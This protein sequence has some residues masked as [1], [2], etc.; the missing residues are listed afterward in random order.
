MHN[1]DRAVLRIGTGIGLATGIC[2]GL[3][4]PMPH[5]GVIMAWVVLCRPG[6]PLGLKKGLAG[7]ILLLGIMASGVLLVPLLTH[8]A[9]AA[10]L[11]VGLLLYLLM[12]QAMAGKGAA[13]ML[14]IMAITVIPV[15]GLIEQSLAIAIAQMMGVGIL[16]GTLVNRMAH[17]LFPPQPVAGAA[18]RAAP[19]PP[20]HPERLALRAV[21]IVMP[22]WLLALGNPAFYIPAVMKTV[23]L[24]QQSTSLNAKQAGQELVLSTLAGALLAF[25]LWMGLSLWPSLLMLVLMLTLMT[26]WLAR[27]LVRL[28][29][30]RF[31]P[32]FWSNAWITA[33]I[34]FGP[35]IEDSATGKDVWLAAAMRCGL[36]LLVAGY[37][38]L[39]ILLLEQWRPVGRPLAEAKL[40]D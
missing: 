6:E 35:A 34:L 5:L 4:L 26:L 27:R 36:Y 11:L 38:W 9:L 28:V 31:P 8:Y 3:A 16:I 13:A 14:L 37:G 10:V 30:G 15:A 40:G 29:A 2:Y 39:C 7:G 25:A 1:A 32:S 19:P 24:A 18:A 21:A 17:A 20:E 12:Q 23:T 33:L 22:V